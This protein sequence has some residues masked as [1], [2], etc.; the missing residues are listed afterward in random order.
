[1]LPAALAISTCVSMRHHF[2][3]ARHHPPPARRTYQ[4]LC[5]ELW[6]S[7]SPAPQRVPL[8]ACCGHRHRQQKSTIL[9]TCATNARQ[10]VGN[11]RRFEY[12]KRSAPRCE[13]S[14]TNTL[15]ILCVRAYGHG[16]H[17]EADE[18]RKNRF[19][20]TPI[21]QCIEKGVQLRQWP[22]NLVIH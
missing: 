12:I 16:G 9:S 13:A 10:R 15:Y 5:L 22:N 6:P 17:G 11:E 2:L 14:M 1:M 8:A 3:H 20:Q 19:K 4:F 18:L 7:A 21:N